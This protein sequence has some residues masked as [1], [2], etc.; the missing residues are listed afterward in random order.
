[1]ESVQADE[2]A[3]ALGQALRDE[4]CCSCLF[5]GIIVPEQCKQPATP[6][7]KAHS[8]TSMTDPSRFPKAFEL[9]HVV[10][11]L[12][13]SFQFAYG[14]GPLR[15]SGHAAEIQRPH[16]TQEDRPQSRLS[17]SCDFFW[18]TTHISTLRASRS[19]MQFFMGQE[20]RPQEIAE[21]TMKNRKY[22]AHDVC[23]ST[24]THYN[25]GQGQVYRHMSAMITLD[26]FRLGRKIGHESTSAKNLSCWELYAAS[27]P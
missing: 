19:S 22:F 10:M 8:I 15:M 24:R 25:I 3:R 6:T 26:Q 14:E 4:F 5:E 20:A 12:P 9:K 1:M 2:W 7:R 17:Y 18:P 11:K 16:R 21:D 23:P 13:I 27:S